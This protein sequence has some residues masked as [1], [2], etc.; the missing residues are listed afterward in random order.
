MPTA[1][2]MGKFLKAEH[3][4]STALIQIQDQGERAEPSEY[5]PDGALELKVLPYNP[6][7]WA[8]GD[9]EEKTWSVN[10]TSEDEIR[11]V[12]GKDT[13]NWAEQVIRINV[14]NQ[15]VRGTMRQI[16]YSDSEDVE[17]EKPKK[18][19]RIKRKPKP[20]PTEEPLE[21]SELAT[22]WLKLNQ[23]LI[24]ETIPA[25]IWNH[26]AGPVRDE[27]VN[28]ELITTIDDQPH[29]TEEAS[30]YL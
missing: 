27:L 2:P 13:E 25:V 28:A 24:G 30:H 8:T 17:L 18:Q 6:D 10:R 1:R 14:I 22:Y 23:G 29:L 7:N 20:T 15:R 4:G 12:H 16:L 11:N 26:M 21:L 9:L 5:R 19:T 3:I